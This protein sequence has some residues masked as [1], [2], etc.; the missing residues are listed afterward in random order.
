M[1]L[2]SL[3]IFYSGVSEKAFLLEKQRTENVEID[4]VA[5]QIELWIN[6][7]TGLSYIVYKYPSTEHHLPH[8]DFLLEREET[9]FKHFTANPQADNL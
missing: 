6:W 7:K 1:S 9:F 8:V 3:E 4:N 2:E 5:K